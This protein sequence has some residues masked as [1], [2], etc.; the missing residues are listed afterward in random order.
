MFLRPIWKTEKA[1][2][3]IQ[4]QQHLDDEMARLF[5]QQL[6]TTGK[7][8]LLG[9]IAMGLIVVIPY[10]SVSVLIWTVAIS[11]V[12]I[13]RAV[14]MEKVTTRNPELYLIL[15]CRIVIY[16]SVCV[17]GILWG[18]A[19]YLFLLQTPNDIRLPLLL[20]FVGVMTL[21][22]PMMSAKPFSGFLF[23]GPILIG[24]VMRL[25]AQVNTMFWPA[26]VMVTILA[27]FT[28]AITYRY[29]DLIRKN[30]KLRLDKETL[31]DKLVKAK[32]QAEETA[33]AKSAYLATM[34]HE[35][36][37]PIN[38]LMGMLDILKETELN[39]IQENY[40]KTASRSA[41]SLLQLLNDILD[42][43][44]IEVGKLE[45]ERLPF[46]WVAVVG[47]IAMM[48]RV[49]ASDKG[50]AFHLDIP[51]EGTSIII[52]DP[53]RLRQILNN[54]L[55]NALKFTNEGSVSLKV[56]IESETAESVVFN[57]SVTDTG[58]G[59]SEEAQKNLFQ[60]FQQA[61]SSTSR[62]YGG[63]GLG[64]SISQQLA[65]LMG[66]QIRLRSEPGKGSEFT[67]TV[68][69]PKASADTVANFCGSID[70]IRSIR[71]SAK[72]LLVEDDPVSQR[73]AVIMLKS[74][75]ITPVVVNTGGAA[76]EVAQREHFDVIFM[77]LK[78]PDME[79]FDA[80]SRITNEFEKFK[81]SG[82]QTPVIVALSGA[83]TLEDREHASS[84]GISEFIP[85]PVRKR[86][87]RQCL[88]R[89]LNRNSE[90]VVLH[91]GQENKASV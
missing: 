8:G 22:G 2:T 13:L 20:V 70:P 49:L 7:S 37:T 79:G 38:G 68:P 35:I 82:S 80:A 58:I 10:H 84:C 67:L 21:S 65:H 5:F 57:F 32:Q 78:L 19:A 74:F 52:G 63:S 43:S 81:D 28:L 12:Y 48:N 86:E 59:I 55:S 36:R 90:P 61:S 29:N 76:V 75:G 69:F 1:S 9:A 3:I 50:I 18:I 54:L 4:Q 72:V 39:G 83:D 71:F 87:M 34:S 44:K 26:T 62:N 47:E 14:I 77:D 66:G 45:L 51:P 91:S 27:I 42:Y 40:L 30:I 64:L 85:K 33:R 41:E 25:H 88:A 11:A 53:T 46:D 6:K 31:V 15:S 24:I 16:T 56:N 73:V 89:H 60:K 17:L 23:V